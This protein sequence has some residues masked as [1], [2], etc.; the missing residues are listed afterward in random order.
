MKWRQQLIEAALS[1]GVRAEDGFDKAAWQTR[2]E[3]SD[4]DAILAF[5]E[6]WRKAGDV[7]WGD[8]G[9]ST[10]GD[11]NGGGE[12]TSS[13]IYPSYLFEYM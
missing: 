8:G 6:T 10:T 12:S 13:I 7:R 3:A 5:T 4:S 11:G 2:L 1:E 9:R